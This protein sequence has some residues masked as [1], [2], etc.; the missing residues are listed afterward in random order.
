MTTTMTSPPAAAGD[1][2]VRTP[3]LRRRVVLSV[4]GLLLIVLTALGLIMNWVLGTQLRADVQ[5]RLL[6]RAQ[7]AQVLTTQN[8]PAQAVVDQL[9]GQ[10]ITAQFTTGQQTLIGR[11]NP[12]PPPP[13]GKGGHKPPPTAGSAVAVQHSGDQL[14]TQLNIQGG[15][16]VL[17]ASQG[18]VDQTLSTLSHIELAAGAA[19]VLLTGLLLIRVV[20]TALGPLDRMTALADRIRNGTRGRRLHPTRPGTELG[21][22]A[23][24]FDGMLDALESAEADAHQA[25]DRMRQFLADASHD[26]RTPLAGVIGNAELLLRANPPRAERETRLVD[27]VREAQRAARLVDDLLLIT[28]LDTPQ[29]TLR[30]EPV[31]LTDVADRAITL[32]RLRRPDRTITLSAAHATVSGDPDHLQRALAN[33]LDNATTATPPGGHV[34]LT[35]TT[36]P[37]QVRLSVADTGPGVGEGDRHRIFDR[38]VRLSTARSGAGTGLGLPIA[39]AIAAAH[40]GEL[41]YLPT[42]AGAR[43]DLTLP[44]T[45][46]APTPTAARPHRITPLLPSR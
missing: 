6:D 30:R 27:L 3:S 4:L 28:R 22:T 34:T 44:T 7:F 17:Q 39:R 21:Q 14:S 33:L 19:T 36:T 24:A 5:Q 11:D 25:E 12:T 2:A 23:V 26:L 45:T 43:F 41:H 31:A 29:P 16:L 18:G 9:A 15:T 32:A 8:L 38:F 10:G 40:G 42:P 1:A 20:H 37:G 13:P 46:V 35:I